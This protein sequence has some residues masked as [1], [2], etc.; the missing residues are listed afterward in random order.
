MEWF[1]TWKVQFAVVGAIYLS[2][3]LKI[4]QGCRQWLILTIVLL[5]FLIQFNV[6]SLDIVIV[7][8]IVKLFCWHF[9][10]LIFA[11]ELITDLIAKL[12][13][14]SYHFFLLLEKINSRY[15][16]NNQTLQVR[17]LLL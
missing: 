14:G 16:R 8:K 10:I 1:K 7:I 11:S 5:H 4:H 3:N 17:F 6:W 12:P 9:V 15:C 13:P 2:S